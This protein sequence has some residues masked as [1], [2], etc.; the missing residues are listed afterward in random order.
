MLKDRSANQSR[1]FLPT[2]SRLTMVA[3][4]SALPSAISCSPSWDDRKATSSPPKARAASRRARAVFS[5]FAPS[6]AAA[7]I[8]IRA[9]RV[10]GCLFHLPI[11]V[12]TYHLPSKKKV[13]GIF[14]P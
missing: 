14:S 4:L 9:A 3:F 13:P 11:S 5:W 12:G 8:K 7:T 1:N 10:N 2:R 6:R